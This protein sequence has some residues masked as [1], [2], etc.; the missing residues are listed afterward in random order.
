MKVNNEITLRIKGDME[1]FKK[2]LKEKGY[3]EKEQFILY[4]VFMVPENLELDKMTTREIISKAIII[5]KVEDITK[6]EI[7]RDIS[8]KIKKF[9][10]NGEILEQKSIRLKILSCE[11]AEKFMEAIGY[12]KLMNIVEKD[13]VY[14]KDGFSLATKE[15]IGGDN[16]IEAETEID[17]ENLNT[18][19]KLK[20][21]LEQ[22]NMPLDF[23]DCFVK[24]AEVELNKILGRE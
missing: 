17:N 23:K 21:K 1:Q 6:N 5:R 9:N 14:E 13:Y 15:V 3:E 11:D 19:D 18:I 10:D 22:E 16:M 2:T 24:K 20:A 12:K 7:R 8:Y 4:D